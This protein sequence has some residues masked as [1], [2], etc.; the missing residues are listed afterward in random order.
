MQKASKRR[1]RILAAGLLAISAI[2][3]LAP[4][5]YVPPGMRWK[6]LL[7]A[8]ALLSL[9]LTGLIYPRAI[10]D[11][12]PPAGAIGSVAE[13]GSPGLVIGGCAFFIGLAIGAWL[14]LGG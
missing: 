4:A 1:R 12:R 14:A 10:P 9:G 5:E 3:F 11:P 2:V 13:A 7:A 6:G 8:P